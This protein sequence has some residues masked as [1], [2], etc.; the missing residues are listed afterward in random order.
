MGLAY[1]ENLADTTAT[2]TTDQEAVEL[3]S[4]HG[5]SESDWLILFSTGGAVDS[6]AN[7]LFRVA[8]MKNDSL[9]CTERCQLEPEDASSSRIQPVQ[10]WYMNEGGASSDTFQIKVSSA[11][12]YD[13]RI[14]DAQIMGID[15]GNITKNTDWLIGAAEDGTDDTSPST[16]TWTTI[17]SITIPAGNSGEKWLILGRMMFDFNAS[18]AKC[19]IRILDGASGTASNDGEYQVVSEDSSDIG[20]EV[21]M[22]LYEVPDASAH[23]LNLQFHVGNA[24]TDIQDANIIGV[25]LGAISDVIDFEQGTSDESHATDTYTAY[26]NTEKTVNFSETGDY[27]VLAY[28]AHRNASDNAKGSRARLS[29]IGS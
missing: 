10:W 23:T 20:S 9:I 28:L 3:S 8:W 14:D 1:N 22:L 16:N 4:T 26:S 11:G 29:I 5:I 12:S 24:N 15:L 17:T 7:G 2:S 18:G 27:A 13:T 25:N 19:R 6:D 21:I